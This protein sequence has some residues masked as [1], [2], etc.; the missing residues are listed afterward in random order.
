VDEDGV[1]AKT[2]ARSQGLAGDLEK[3]ALIHN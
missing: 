2:A 3:H 1:D